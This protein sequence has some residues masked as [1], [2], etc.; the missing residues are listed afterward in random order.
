MS[1]AYAQPSPSPSSSQP[2]QQK[3]VDAVFFKNGGVL[4]GEII[5][6]TSKTGKIRLYDGSVI[7]FRKSDVKMIS[8]IQ[9]QEQVK[10]DSLKIA[11]ISKRVLEEETERRRE[12]EELMALQHLV[13]ANMQANNSMVYDDDSEIRLYSMI[14]AGIG[15]GF[16][17]LPL[18]EGESALNKGA[19]THQFIALRYAVGGRG[20]HFGLGVSLGIQQQRMSYNLG[21]QADSL[22]VA[23][24]LPDAIP[25]SSLFLPIG[26]DMRL[27]FLSDP[28]ASPFISANATYAVSLNTDTEKDKGGFFTINPAIGMRFGHDVNSLLSAGFQLH[29]K[30]NGDAVYFLTL[31]FGVIF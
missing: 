18:P 15:I 20:D 19:N 23:L 4:R 2:L 28:P 24:P 26:L 22:G 21:M 11:G 13:D 9:A 7:V 27:E 14:D 5:K 8:K 30:P 1:P 12:E 3:K 16:G 25:L 31:R 10:D 29:V 6:R 17:D